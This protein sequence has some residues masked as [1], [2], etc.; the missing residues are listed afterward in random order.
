MGRFAA[1][2]S[3]QTNQASGPRVTGIPWRISAHSPFGV[4]VMIATPRTLSPTGSARSSG[5]RPEPL[6]GGPQVRSACNRL[7]WLNS[8]PSRAFA[9]AEFRKIPW[10]PSQRRQKRSGSGDAVRRLIF[11]RTPRTV[12]GMLRATAA[13]VA[14]AAIPASRNERRA[15]RRTGTA[16]RRNGVATAPNM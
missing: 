15:S 12:A 13:E 9:H 7:I 3:S 16:T 14:R 8:G 6:V 1:L 4:V 11:S 2:S 10:R 5:G